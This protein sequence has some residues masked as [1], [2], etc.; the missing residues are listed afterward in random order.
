M[1]ELSDMVNVKESKIDNVIQTVKSNY[2]K[3]ATI[4]YDNTDNT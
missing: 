2:A 4:Q 3:T 1:S